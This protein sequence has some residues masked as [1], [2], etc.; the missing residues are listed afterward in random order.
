[1]G[2]P[3]SALGDSLSQNRSVEQV[4]ALVIAQEVM[5]FTLTQVAVWPDA[6]RAP[7][8][9][10]TVLWV[11]PLKYWVIDGAVDAE[12]TLDLSASRT[13]IKLSG[14]KASTLLNHFLPLN[15]SDTAFPDGHVASSGIHH[16]GVTLWREAEVFNLFIPRSYAMTIWELIE[17]T[18][19]QY[20]LDIIG[21]AP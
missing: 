3:V 17:G 1:M 7:K 12:F 20:G 14:P 4:P 8:T 9:D 19:A 11:E 10:G 13:W 21:A 6:T 18:A 15:L 2:N 5:G 16:V